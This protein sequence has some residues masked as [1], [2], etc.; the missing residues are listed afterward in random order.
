MI[1][2]EYRVGRCTIQIIQEHEKVFNTCKCDVL[3]IL[4][5]NKYFIT[6]QFKHR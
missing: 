6:F 3:L 4:S 1:L 2:I 5:F